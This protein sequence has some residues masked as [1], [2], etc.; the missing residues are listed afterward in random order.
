MSECKRFV[1]SRVMVC[2]CGGLAVVAAMTAPAAAGSSYPDKPAWIHNASA[3]IL[4]NF[5]KIDAFM[6]F[7]ID[8]E[9]DWRVDSSPESLAA[10]KASWGTLQQGAYLDGFPYPGPPDTS[11]IDA[12]EAL[13]EHHQT[14][15]GWYESLDMPFPS[16]AVN[17]VQGRG[18]KPYIVWEPFDGSVPGETARSGESR[19]DDILAGAYDTRIN[20][21]AQAAAAN[22]KPMEISFGHEMNGDWFTWGYLGGHNGNTA[23][24]YVEAFRYVVDKFNAAGATNVDWVWCINA[25]WHDDFSMAFP[26]EQYVDRMGMNGFNWGDDPAGGGPDY[27]KWR[28]FERIFGQWDPYFPEGVHNYNRLVELAPNLPIIVGEFGSSGVPEPATLALLAAGGLVL[29]RRRR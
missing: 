1:V 4:A 27:A 24:Q 13:V 9:R 28:D 14:R 25:S 3:Q 16:A 29:A 22:G 10:Y 6:W 23:A 19:L 7:N 21:W 12:F 15:I 2:L 8:K 11:K 20:D 17:A 18:S 26:G 5:P